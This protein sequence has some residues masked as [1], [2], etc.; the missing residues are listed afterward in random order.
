M[1]VIEQTKVELP[2]CRLT[3]EV[4]KQV[5]KLI[6]EQIKELK[7]L[8]AKSDE[9]EE[10]EFALETTSKKLI[11]QSYEAFVNAN[12]SGKIEEFSVRY[13]GSI[14]ILIRIEFGSPFSFRY[15]S[16]SGKDTIKANGISAKLE[17]IFNQSL[18]RNYLFHTPRSLIPISSLCGIVLGFVAHF[19][20]E[21]YFRHN[22]HDPFSFSGGMI[23]ISILLMFA[24]GWILSWL[25]PLTEF[26]NQAVQTRIRKAVIPIVIGIV[27]TLAGS[28]IWKMVGG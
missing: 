18:T 13:Y 14:N 16:V 19:F 3:K 23:G 15:F 2:S 17:E 27:I 11:S 21:V 10:I 20:Y 28:V 1:S 8:K 12:W 9:Q 24:S 6:D 26:E 5:C 22:L 7:V 25:F 4:I